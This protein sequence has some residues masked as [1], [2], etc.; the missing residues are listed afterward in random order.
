MRTPHTISL[1]IDQRRTA[2]H[3]A[4]RAGDPETAWRQLEEAHILSQPW[5]GAHTRVHIDMLALALRSR[6]PHEVAGQLLRIVL[7]GVG[8]A[9][10][11]Y[12]AGNTGRADVSAFRPMPMPAQLGEILDQARGR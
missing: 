6:A 1:E 4:S 2:S 9:L 11:R 10:G 12:P 5:P 3:R 7:A 8:S